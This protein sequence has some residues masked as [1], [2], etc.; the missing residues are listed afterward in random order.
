MSVR[1]AGH[2]GEGADLGEALFDAILKG[3]SGVVFD[4]IFDTIARGRVFP[5]DE[6][7][8][9]IILTDPGS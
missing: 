3:R 7:R 9:S 5:G 8:R 4:H 1:R 2:V 6:D